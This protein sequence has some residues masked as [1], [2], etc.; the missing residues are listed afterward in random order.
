MVLMKIVK[1]GGVILGGL[2][3]VASAHAGPGD[4]NSGGGPGGAPGSGVVTVPE[5]STWLLMAAG[6][7]GIA[8]VARAKKK[9]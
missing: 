8:F 6:V 1:W 2:L 9:K 3:F 5:P 7:A 4:P